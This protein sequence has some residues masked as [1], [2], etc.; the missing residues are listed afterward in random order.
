MRISQSFP[1]WRDATILAGSLLLAASV[2]GQPTQACHDCLTVSNIGSSG[3]DGVESPADPAAIDQLM[4][5]LPGPGLPG[6]SFVYVYGTSVQVSYLG[7]TWAAQ[8]VWRA[9]R[10]VTTSGFCEARLRDSGCSPLSW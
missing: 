8:A 3:D 7:L 1:N 6:T 4:G 5:A 9:W 10:R 2:L